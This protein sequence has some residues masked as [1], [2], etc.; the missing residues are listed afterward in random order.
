MSILDND[1]QKKLEELIEEEV[2]KAVYNKMGRLDL[3]TEI[4]KRILEFLDAKFKTVGLP[5]ASISHRAINWNSFDPFKTILKQS[6]YENFASTGIQDVAPQT[7]LTVAD[8][9]VVVENT[10]IT[11]NAE[12]KD[13]FVANDAAI[14]VL[15]IND[16][17]VLNEKI[18]TQFI[19]LIKETVHKDNALRKINVTSNPIM[20]NDKEVLTDNSLGPSIINSNL[21]KLGR[22]NELNVSG[23]AQFN[24]TLIVTT[25]GKIGINTSEPEGALTIWDDDSEITF[26]RSKKKTMYIGSMRD[27]EIHLGTNNNTHLSVRRDGIIEMQSIAINGIKIS[28]A[29]QI[30]NEVGIPGEIVI[31]KNAGENDPWAYRCLGGDKW[32]AIK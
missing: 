6:I 2:K 24:D 3:Q 9:V 4:G 20:A 31:M 8:Q 32:K 5:E 21:R 12:I 25:S 29:D 28:V 14:N 30:P 27:T 26:K 19:N 18:N 13:N 23:I 1:Y 17:L 22:L 11:R 15:T 7:E 16:K 10:L